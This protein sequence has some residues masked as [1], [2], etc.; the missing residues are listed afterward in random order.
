[1]SDSF[2]DSDDVPLFTSILE[3]FG[4]KQGIKL[5]K[6]QH[7][8]YGVICS[9]F[10]LKLLDYDELNDDEES[11]DVKISHVTSTCNKELRRLAQD[12]ENRLRAYGGN[13][14]LIM[15]LTGPAGAGKSTAV[16]A[17]EQFCVL[18]CRYAHIVWMFSSYLYTA[19]TGSNS[20]FFNGVTICKKAGTKTK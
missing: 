2:C 6:K 3:W 9:S 11:N 1:M 16:K 17:A 12:A 10:L 8:A 4:V 18:F 5:D 20:A 14:Q 7:M 19:Y 15:F 13:R